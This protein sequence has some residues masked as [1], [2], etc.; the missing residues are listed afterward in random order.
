MTVAAASNQNP[1]TDLISTLN[2]ST[3]KSGKSTSS[4][5]DMQNQFLTMLI[6]QLK[7]QDPMNPMDNAQ[8]TTQ[9][10]QMSTVQGITQLNSSLSSLLTQNQAT[11]MLQGASLVGHQVLATGDQLTLS[12]AGAA[13]GINLATAADKVQVTISDAN[14]TPVKTLTLGQQ[15][16]GFMRFAWDGTN[17]TGQALPTGQ[18]SFAVT[19][20]AGG[21]AVDATTYAL[22]GVQSVSMVNG[23]VNAEVSGL[24]ERGMN[25]IQQIF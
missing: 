14:G 15:P 19:A 10:A 6:T 23:A 13:A 12:T 2:G 21:K 5:Q 20:S 18:Y 7:N 9:L 24:G 11:Q 1:Q 3:A 8:L 25:Q 16:S 17:N 22:G 4:V